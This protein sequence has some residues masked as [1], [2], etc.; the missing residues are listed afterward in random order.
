[1]QSRQAFDDH[2]L[3]ITTNDDMDF[4]NSFFQNLDLDD[5]MAKLA[6][7]KRRKCVSIETIRKMVHSQV[8]LSFSI[9][10]RCVTA[11]SDD[12]DIAR[13]STFRAKG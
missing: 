9:F 6:L 2:F 5:H 13:H 11:V 1:M 12:S 4:V 3:Q 8:K 7:S 10:N